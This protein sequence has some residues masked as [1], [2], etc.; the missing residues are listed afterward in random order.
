MSKT[1]K[2]SARGNMLFVNTILHDFIKL[3]PREIGKNFRDVLTLKIKNA[4]EGKCTRYGYVVPNSVQLLH[5]SCGKL[6]GASLNGDIVYEVEYQA[7]VCNPAENSVVQARVVN[8]N[9]FGIL[10]HGG[11]LPKDQFDGVVNIL[12]IIVAKQAVSS[13]ASDVDLNRVRIGDVVQVQILG[14]RFELNDTRITVVGKIL[15]LSSSVDQPAVGTG[16]LQ[17]NGAVDGVDDGV[18]EDDDGVDDDGT[19]ADMDDAAESLTDDAGDDDDNSDLPASDNDDNAVDDDDENNEE[20][21]DT[22][23]QFLSDS[24]GIGGDASS[25]DAVTSDDE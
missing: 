6:D 12:E 23:E 3:R 8:V 17:A 25:D 19:S 1:E 7:T 24:D 10:A 13:L 21:A 11:Q 5:H 9:R 20:D 15:G 4:N 18:V 2:E 16:A 22:E 14:K